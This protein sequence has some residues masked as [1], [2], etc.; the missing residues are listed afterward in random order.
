MS[1]LPATAKDM[2]LVEAILRNEERVAETRK[3]PGGVTPSEFTG[4]GA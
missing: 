3:R 1:H 2:L 4:E